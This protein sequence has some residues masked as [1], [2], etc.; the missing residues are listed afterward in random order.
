MQCHTSSNEF[1]NIS[2]I[3]RLTSIK[4][5]TL[6]QP[7]F[8]VIKMKQQILGKASRCRSQGKEKLSRVMVVKNN[9]PAKPAI[10][11]IPSSPRNANCRRNHIAW[12]TTLDRVFTDD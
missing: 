3:K 2:R 11:S 12:P 10:P 8:S 1:T 6:H 9:R 5:I 7:S 4:P